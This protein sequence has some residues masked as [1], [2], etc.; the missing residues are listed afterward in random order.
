M[1][2]EAVKKKIKLLHESGA[3]PL[4]Y[5]VVYWLKRLRHPEKAS[6]AVIEQV[7]TLVRDNF[8]A[9]WHV[10]I[11]ADPTA[12]LSLPTHHKFYPALATY[13]ATHH[14]HMLQHIYPRTREWCVLAVN[15]SHAAWA[16]VPVALQ[17]SVLAERLYHL[18]A[19]LHPSPPAMAQS[20]LTQLAA[21]EAEHAQTSYGLSPFSLDHQ[22]HTLLWAAG[23]TLSPLA[24]AL[25]TYL[26]VADD[27]RTVLG[28]RMRL[29]SLRQKLTDPSDHHANNAILLSTAVFVPDAVV[30]TVT[31]AAAN[32]L[33]ADLFQYT[34]LD[35]I[36]QYME[37][38]HHGR[39]HK[40]IMTAAGQHRSRHDLI[41][42]SSLLLQLNWRYP[43]DAKL[44]TT[45]LF[46]GTTPCTYMHQALTSCAFFT[47]ERYAG[48]V[49]DNKTPSLATFLILPKN[50]A[51]LG[52]FMTMA[53]LVECVSTGAKVVTD[54][55]YQPVKLTVPRVHLNSHVDNRR[56]S[57][58][59]E[60]HL[61]VSGLD[62][63]RLGR[64][65]PSKL[66]AMLQETTF[67]LT[68]GSGTMMPPWPADQPAEILV[69]DQPFL[70][71]VMNTDHHGAVNIVYVGK[72]MADAI[73][74]PDEKK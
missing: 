69:L 29:R 17:A 50:G 51:T 21:W 62:L 31:G 1:A 55:R 23:E 56:L 60:P 33:D 63:P 73:V 13:I 52:S 19:G 59:V 32:A 74:P 40:A 10:A 70:V 72:I 42:V 41:L 67:S 26:E 58:A 68:E 44:N 3:D 35:H 34:S 16:F 39:G 24:S 4:E 46:A 64:A 9:V 7:P 11:K 45:G 14:G 66:S 6:V 57:S 30:P 27:P 18:A 49:L 37:G 8:E 28:E 61:C 43:F 12:F 5:D 54:K 25:R 65:R 20:H 71:I 48:V 15:S 53:N 36:N 47:T 38:T 22:L 2:S